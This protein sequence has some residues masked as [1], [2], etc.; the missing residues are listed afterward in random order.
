MNRDSESVFLRVRGLDYHCRVWGAPGAP[1]LFMLHGWMDVSAS[2]Q[3]VVEALRGE[4]RV[5]APDWRGF[6]LTQWSGADSYWFPDYLGDLDAILNV[7]ALDAPVR[8]CGHSMGGNIAALYAGVRPARVRRL[9][10]L[11]GFGLPRTRPGAAPRRYAR[12]L[13]EL[14]ARQEFRDYDGFDE[15][16]QRLRERNP[17]LGAERAAF[18]AR[19]WGA[20]APG[21][22]VR[23]RA[24]PAHRRVNPVQYQLD[25]AQACWAAVRCP[26]LWVE[27]A[28][29][30]S[31]EQLHVS[32]DE[33]VAR[34]SAMPGTRTL[35]IP[36]AGH[37]LHH[38]QP[39]LLAEAME[40]FL[41]ED[42]G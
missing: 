8:L 21:G 19:H 1:L 29:S 20:D 6:G 37:M 10:N 2:F 13:S 18:L 5:I 34:R 15:L 42:G 24:D 38:D 41:L 11:E 3:F 30:R 22:R 23:L 16:A 14:P 39:V 27:G 17:R 7:F 9:I 40:A 31:P 35:V 28:D 32:P 25:E 12:W 33:L 36:G 26:V 4:W